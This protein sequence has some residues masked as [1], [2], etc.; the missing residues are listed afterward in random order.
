M[1]GAI[2]FLDVSLWGKREKK[3]KNDTIIKGM[4]KY[5]WKYKRE[6]VSVLR[7]ISD[8]MVALY[9]ST[10]DSRGD[11]MDSYRLVLR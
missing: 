11:I 2:G 7:D 10:V 6:S 1:L 5:K 3:E 4:W 8:I 9:V